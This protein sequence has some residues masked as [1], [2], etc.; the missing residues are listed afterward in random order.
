MHSFE[1]LNLQSIAFMFLGACQEIFP[2]SLFQSSEIILNS[3][4]SLAL[5][6]S[7]SRALGEAVA[8]GSRPGVCGP[9]QG[10][11]VGPTREGPMHHP[12]DRVL[13]PT[14]A[15]RRTHRVLSGFR[16]CTGLIWKPPY[17]FSVPRTVFSSTW[18]LVFEN[19][20]EI[21]AAVNLCSK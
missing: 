13:S 1:S 14:A 7:P 10:A 12:W 6:P 17:L 21:Q 20:L 19:G 8:G 18:K 4:C 9:C 15:G 11:K 5:G 2:W 16:P 3:K